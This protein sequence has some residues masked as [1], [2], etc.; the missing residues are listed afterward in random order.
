MLQN[1]EANRKNGLFWILIIAAAT[2]LVWLAPEEKQLGQGIKSVYVHVAL[3][4]VGMAGLVAAGLIGIGVLLSASRKLSAWMETVGWVA[5]GFYAAGVSMSILASKVNWGNVFWQEPRMKV[6]LNMLALA[7]IVEIFVSWVP[8]HRL[9]GFLS[10]LLV[11]IL[12]WTTMSAPLVLHPKNAISS[13]SS[14]GIK[15]TF[16]GL[17]LLIAAAAAWIVWFVKSKRALTD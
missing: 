5:L 13:S 14:S 17:S 16:L 6:A 2:V 8:W 9:K 4:W 1:I 12:A 15:M 3:I 11:V 7:L 10:S